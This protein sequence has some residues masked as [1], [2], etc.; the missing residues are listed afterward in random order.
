MN[1]F[2]EYKFKRNTFSHEMASYFD[3]I[4]NNIWSTYSFEKGKSM[5]RSVESLIDS[6][7]RDKILIEINHVELGHGREQSLMAVKSEMKKY[8][9]YLL[10]K[11]R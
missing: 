5:W 9:E 4:L 1:Q 8:L 2:S 7:Y 6:P 11:E 3:F 10:Q